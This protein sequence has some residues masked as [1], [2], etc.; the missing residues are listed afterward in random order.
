MNKMILNMK[1]WLFKNNSIFNNYILQDVLENDSCNYNM[2][3]DQI[4]EGKVSDDDLLL[5]KCS[6]YDIHKLDIDKVI[7][8]SDLRKRSLEGKIK[9]ENIE[10][11]FRNDMNLEDKILVILSNIKL[12]NINGILM[13]LAN[14]YQLP[15]FYLLASYSRV[16]GVIDDKMISN[17]EEFT[18]LNKS[19]LG[20]VGL[21]NPLKPNNFS[22]ETL[23]TWREMSTAFALTFLR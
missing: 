5:L 20:Y 14:E 10:F 15:L 18:R 7:F 8:N 22:N 1:E 12:V 6:N 9:E 16:K 19:T 3:N 13:Y 17:I 21:I 2:C 4:N 11:L 23:K